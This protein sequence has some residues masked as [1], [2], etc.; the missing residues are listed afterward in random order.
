[1]TIEHETGYKKDV[2][3][4]FKVKENYVLNKESCKME[5]KVEFLVYDDNQEWMYL[6]GSN[7][8]P[9]EKEHYDKILK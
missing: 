1:M 3:E 2:Y 8:K 9:V 7:C 5:L 4:V 6:D